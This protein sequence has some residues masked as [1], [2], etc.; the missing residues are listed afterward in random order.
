[1]DLTSEQLEAWVYLLELV[2]NGERLSDITIWSS[3]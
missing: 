1:M 2:L 3:S